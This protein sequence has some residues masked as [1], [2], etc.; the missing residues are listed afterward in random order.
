MFNERK[1][2]RGW[3]LATL[4]FIAV[5]GFLS[6]NSFAQ[7]SGKKILL[8]EI[9]FDGNIKTDNEYL[10][11]LLPY[12][13]GDTLLLNEV[14]LD[15]NICK[16]RLLNS[17]LF[18][19][20]KS[21]LE[22]LDTIQVTFHFSL[23]ERFYTLIIPVVDVYDRNFNSWFVTHKHDFNRVEYGLTFSQNNINGK[24]N[25]LRAYALFGFSQRFAIGYTIPFFD[26]KQ[27]WGLNSLVS[28][29]RNK[30]I[31]Y[32]SDSN[33]EQILFVPKEF[34]RRNF[35]SQLDL[36]YKPK[37]H[38]EQ[39][40]S[41][42]YNAILI[43]DT[44]R[45]RNNFYLADSLLHENY[46]SIAYSF[47]YDTRNIENYPTYGSLI[48]FSMAKNG[49]GK[50]DNLNLWSASAQLE[51]YFSLG[52]K[53]YF[54]T[55]AKA[56][57]ISQ[58]YLNYANQIGLGYHRDY[59]SGYEYYVADGNAFALWKNEFKYNLFTY[60]IKVFKTAFVK[61]SS[62]PFEFY[63]KIY[64][65]CGYVM[66]AQ[67]QISNTLTNY[68]LRGFG[69]GFDIVSLYDTSVSFEYSVNHLGESGLYLH[70]NSFF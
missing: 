24:G 63:P 52:N 6:N 53:F 37:I 30:N 43:E 13:K 36:V 25:L 59:V 34:L 4:L 46:F 19:D 18:I 21:G 27:H 58:S 56:K 62:I 54:N 69:A 17:G 9:L 40:F 29:S 20:V 28:Y 1:K 47:S 15:I 66:N 10:L 3:R 35:K 7:G 64:F 44:L 55:K 57:Y 16:D 60:H 33:R 38:C 41:F 5:V 68:F 70:F 48:Q 31:T 49:L 67:N 22:N 11:R 61:S 50:F 8:R 14:I 26:K 42:S 12:H 2:Q 45:K 39:T 32:N 65:D 51:K 23:T